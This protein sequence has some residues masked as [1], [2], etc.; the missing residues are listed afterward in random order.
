M[1]KVGLKAT[2]H[3]YSHHVI[4]DTR[5]SY[6]AKPGI[7]SKGDEDGRYARESRDNVDGL[8]STRVV[9]EGHVAVGR[10]QK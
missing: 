3:C 7:E 10:P 1:C 5:T 4:F 9:G 8:P 6:Q 2:H